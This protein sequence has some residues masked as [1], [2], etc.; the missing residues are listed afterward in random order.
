LWIENERW[1]LYMLG[2]S[3][4]TSPGLGLGATRN[5]EANLAYIVSSAQNTKA[6]QELEAAHLNADLIGS[7]WE[8]RWQPVPEAGEDAPLAGALP[9][10]PFFG[11]AIFDVERG[12][13][14]ITF[15]FNR[16]PLAGWSLLIEDSDERFADEAK[17]REAKAPVKWRVSWPHQR[18]PS[19]FRVSWESAAGYAWW[20][21]NTQNGAALPPP[22][23]LKDLPLDV[24]VALLTSA[25]PPHEI[26]RKHR[27]QQ[28]EL[29]GGG[30]LDPHDRVDTSSFLLQRTRRVSWALAGLRERLER[31]IVS[32]QSLEW[33]VNGPIG[34]RALS[35]AIEREARTEAERAFLLAELVLELARVKPPSRHD[36]LP[37]TEVRGA[38]RSLIKDLKGRVNRATFDQTPGLQDY[39]NTAFK[40]A[41][42]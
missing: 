41:H 28:Q 16:A 23:D 31:P 3:N 4:F 2:S 39:V 32:Q 6:L 9:L 29:K 33:R 35:E 1:A 13:A 10:P 17:W 22:E 8:L 26:V 30:S 11:E 15:S 27:Q 25:R 20:P 5:L 24:L 18:P 37:P 21:V 14:S 7:D 38:L 40:E 12:C 36:C 42:R 19:G 34:A